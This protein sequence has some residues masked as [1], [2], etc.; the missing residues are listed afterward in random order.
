LAHARREEIAKPGFE[1]CP[2]VEY[3]LRENRIQSR[4]LYWLQV[5]EGSSKHLWPK[6][7]RATVSFRCWDFP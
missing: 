5:P 7:A 4:R 3:I 1:S 2:G 6:R